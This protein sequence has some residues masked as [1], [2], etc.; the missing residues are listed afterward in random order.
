MPF[1]TAEEY[2]EV[3]A[4]ATKM[5]GGVEVLVFADGVVFPGQGI[6]PNTTTG[7]TPWIIGPDGQKIA[8]NGVI[9][10]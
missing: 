10:K 5:V 6:D 7:N 2:K 3:M 4:Y 8:A 9:V 1:R